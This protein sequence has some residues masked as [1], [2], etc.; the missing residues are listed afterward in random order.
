VSQRAEAVLERTKVLL[1]AKYESLRERENA[2]PLLSATYSNLEVD[3]LNL[4]A[5]ADPVERN[6]LKLQINEFGQTPKQIFKITHPPRHDFKVQIYNT[7]KNNS[8]VKYQPKKNIL[9]DLEEG[10]DFEIVESSKVKNNVEIPK[11]N[12][13]IRGGQAGC[14]VE[15]GFKIEV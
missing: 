8:S 7:P 3:L 15:L 6:A 13:G 12:W 14:D 1:E 10:D 2:V 11:E 9:G 4:D 5:V